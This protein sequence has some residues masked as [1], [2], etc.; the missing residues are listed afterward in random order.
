MK[1]S[2]SPLKSEASMTVAVLSD[3]LYGYTSGHTVFTRRLIEQ[4]ADKM[5]RIIV[6]TSGPR[7]RYEERGKI[8]IYTLKGFRLR[9]FGE[10]YIGYHPLSSLRKILHDEKVEVLHCQNPSFMGMLAT[11]YAHR[12]GL[13]AI[14]SSHVQA[15]NLT[16]NLRHPVPGLA[17][18]LVSFARRQYLSSDYLVCPSEYARRELVAYGLDCQEKTSVISNGVDAR[19]YSPDGKTGKVILFVGRLAREKCVDTLIRA[20]AIV[21]RRHPDY[22]TLIVG[23]GFLADELKKLAVAVGADIGFE[24]GVCE[25]DLLERYRSCAL[26]VLPSQFELQGIALLEAMACGKPTIASDSGTSAA[27]DCANIVFRHGDHVDLAGKICAL[28]ETPGEIGRLGAEN[29]ARILREHDYTHVVQQF[30]DLYSLAKEHKRQQAPS[31][32]TRRARRTSIHAG[33]RAG[34]DTWRVH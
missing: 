18:A 31:R 26:F 20:S 15:E 16:R 10:L 33:S 7:V 9:K 19:R 23:S 14:I 6:I 25:E 3:V 4:L 12:L 8:R 27:G 1:W 34:A 32:R 17:A 30:L 11:W 21:Q 29:R 22:R 5:E 24:Q 28:I 2:K 13:P